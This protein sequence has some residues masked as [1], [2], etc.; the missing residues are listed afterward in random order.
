MHDKQAAKR[1]SCRHL[2]TSIVGAGLIVGCMGWLPTIA[3]AGSPTSSTS[4]A[5]LFHPNCQV[6]E[7]AANAFLS[8]CRPALSQVSHGAVYSVSP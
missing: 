3:A 5:G 1:R 6:E 4:Y 7:V 8:N 2:L